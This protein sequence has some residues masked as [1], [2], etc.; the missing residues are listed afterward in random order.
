MS[1]IKNLVAYF[2]EEAKRE[3]EYAKRLEE[4]A[5]KSHNL[6]LKAIMKAVSMD[7][8]KHAHLYEALADIIE[9]PRLV[10]EQESEEIAKEIERHI[11]EEREAIEELKRLLEDGRVRGNAAARFIIEMMLKD[12]TFHHA[13]LRRIRDAVI[14]PLVFSEQ[15]YWEAVWRDAVWHGAPGG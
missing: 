10:T 12:E 6:M 14:K 5:A 9:N 7:S 11:E 1:E 8:I 4:T 13:L 15:D 2:R 3:R